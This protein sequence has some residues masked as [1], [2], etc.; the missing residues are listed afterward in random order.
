MTTLFFGVLALAAVIAAFA[1]RDWRLKTT[2]TGF[3]LLWT[4]TLFIVVPQPTSPWWLD[5]LYTV[6]VLLLLLGIQAR[7]EVERARGEPLAMWI[8]VPLGIE[9]VIGLTYLATP[10]VLSPLAQFY[11]I[12]IGFAFQL[13]SIIVISGRRIGLV[14]KALAVCG[15]NGVRPG[16]TMT[17]SFRVGQ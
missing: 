1:T 10:F 17:T 2:A 8:L 14:G 9:V 3:A 5:P 6:S 4:I 16:T 13:V 12:Q 11:I 7:G 15:R